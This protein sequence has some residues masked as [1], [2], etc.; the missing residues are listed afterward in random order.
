MA[1]AIIG[2][3]IISTLLTLLVVPSFYD[4]IEIARER[5]RLKFRARAALRQSGRGVP[6]HARRE[7][8]ATLLFLRFFYRVVRCG[9]GTQHAGGASRG[10]RRA[11]RWI[12]GAG[13]LCRASQALAAREIPAR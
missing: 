13:R 1:V 6:G 9:D 8:W 4:S 7:R 5:R 10:A 12:T 2:G 3:T 11:T